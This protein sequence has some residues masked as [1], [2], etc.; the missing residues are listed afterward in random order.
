MFLH[1]FYFSS[2]FLAPAGSSC[3]YFSMLVCHVEL[4]T[5]INP[6]FFK[7]NLISVL[8][9]QHKC[10]STCSTSLSPLGLYITVLYLPLIESIP[11]VPNWVLISMGILSETH[12]YEYWHLI[13]TYK[14]KHALFVFLGLDYLAQRFP[15]SPAPSIYPHIIL[16]F[17]L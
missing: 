16:L 12:T 15:A 3:S 7:L 4:L 13:S 10:N 17:F 8:S 1:G 11:V 6:S 5:E 14:R 9:Q 2:C